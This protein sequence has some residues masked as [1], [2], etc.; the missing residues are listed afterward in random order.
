MTARLLRL[1]FWPLLRPRASARKRLFERQPWHP[2]RPRDMCGRCNRR[3][4]GSGSGLGVGGGATELDGDEGLVAEHPCVVPRCDQVSVAAA[5][6]N[7][8]TIGVHDV[9][10]TSLHVTEMLGL[11]GLGLHHRLD[12]LRPLP[13]R[14]EREAAHFAAADVDNL[15]LRL[16]RRSGFV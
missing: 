11:A 15:D 14:L 10:A 16:V 3:A 8:S 13:A 7:L 6:I 4:W 5:E 2:A 9:D 1:P 12:A